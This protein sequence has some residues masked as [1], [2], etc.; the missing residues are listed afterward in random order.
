MGC[1]QKYPTVL[2]A[3]ESRALQVPQHRFSW[4]Q[5]MTVLSL[6]VFKFFF[7]VLASEATE[8]WELLKHSGCILL[9]NVCCDFDL[10]A[11]FFVI[12]LGGTYS[13]IAQ[14]TSGCIREL[15]RPEYAEWAVVR[16]ESQ[17][18]Q[19][20]PGLRTSMMAVGLG[21]QQLRGFAT[22]G[23]GS[24]RPISHPFCL[25][26]FRERLPRIYVPIRA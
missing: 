22:W 3:N 10:V 4:C 24:K 17:A 16:E 9:T 20:V 25:C 14:S 11:D 2:C 26:V 8:L 12:S 23:C 19:T 18:V 1:S 21:R 13:W 6:K 15:R 5:Q 7:R